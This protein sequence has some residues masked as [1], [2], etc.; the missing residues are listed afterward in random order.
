MLKKTLIIVTTIN[1]LFQIIYSIFGANDH[2]LFL[3]VIFHP[4]YL[5]IS[6]I[7]SLGVVLLS[8]MK[9]L[10]TIWKKRNDDSIPMLIIFLMNLEYLYFWIK[11]MM[12]Q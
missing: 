4:I 12:I 9:L 7:V 11:L 3:F 8:V 5:L 1:L 6:G 10:T 2:L